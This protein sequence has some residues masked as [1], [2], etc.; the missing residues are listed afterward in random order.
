VKQ[1]PALWRHICNFEWYE[2]KFSHYMRIPCV[3]FPRQAVGWV[4]AITKKFN[5]QLQNQKKLKHPLHNTLKKYLTA[6][7]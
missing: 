5:T 4:E 6:S 2:H 3:I 1:K 7:V